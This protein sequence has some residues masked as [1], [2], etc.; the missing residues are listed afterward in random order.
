[1]SATA[2]PTASSS[3]RAISRATPIRQDRCPRE[4]APQPGASL[5][6]DDV[7]GP[8]ATL[9]WALS[10][11]CLDGAPMADV[12]GSVPKGR[13]GSGGPIY[14]AKPWERVRWHLRMGW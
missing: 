9:D 11:L 8:F 5:V 1:V 4:R 13:V 7:V 12:A 14:H 10:I 2:I 3:S 6:A